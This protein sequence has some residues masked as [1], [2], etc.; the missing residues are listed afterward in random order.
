[1]NYETSDAAAAKCNEP[2]TGSAS[3]RCDYETAQGT[4]QFAAGE[5]SKTIAVPI[6][7]D[8]YAEGN[9]SFTFKLANP[10][11]SG[12]TLGSPSRITVTITDDETINGTNRIDNHGFFVRQR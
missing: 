9:E 10:G 1:M 6:V 7:N 4:L 8:A 2:S 5:T 11:G 3:S 12:S